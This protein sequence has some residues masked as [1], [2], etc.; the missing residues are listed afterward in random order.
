MI[1]IRPIRNKI[2][3]EEVDVETQHASGIILTSKVTG[4][5]KRAK[6]LAVGDEVQE[7]KVDDVIIID[8]QLASKTQY[9]SKIVFIVK[10]DNVIAIFDN[11][12]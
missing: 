4:E 12:A 7:V 2:V 1:M 5:I 9:D 3:V 10:E 11:A 6:V 8:W